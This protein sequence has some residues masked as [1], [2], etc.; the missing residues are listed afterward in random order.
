[1]SLSFGGFVTFKYLLARVCLGAFCGSPLAAWAQ[2]PAELQFSGFGTVGVAATSL[3]DADYR[4]NSEQSVGVGRSS[5]PDYGVD[6]VFG[7]QASMQWTET[8]GAALQMQSR[9]LSDGAQSPYFEW[10]NVRWLITPNITGRVGRVMAPVFM[11]SDSRSIGYSQTTVRLAPDVYQLAPI[12]YVE[13]ADLSWRLAVGDTLMRFNVTSGDVDQ[14]LTVSGELRDYHFDLDI[15]SAE[16]EIENSKFRLAYADVNARLRSPAIAQLDGGITLLTQLNVPGAA[17]VREH[18]DF[19]NNQVDFSGVGYEF[20]DGRWLVQGEYVW[21]TA[22]SETIQDQEAAYL[23]AGHRWGQW[24]PYAQVSRMESRIDLSHLP[25]MN[26]SGYSAPVV[27]G[28]AAV[29]AAIASIRLPQERDTLTLGVRWDLQENVALKLQADR[30]EKE[31]GRLSYF[32]N[33]TPDF[34]AEARNVVVYTATL[35]FIY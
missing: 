2:S 21:R 12:S 34:I 35:D 24:M 1:M 33:A 30:V 29:N 7:V 22:S 6:S 26:A 4:S 23:L 14:S 27:A 10:A 17:T 3:E 13:G 28:T 25:V 31:A 19:E 9:R 5:S 16:L 20:D 18:I 15:F 8:L 32:V 11:V